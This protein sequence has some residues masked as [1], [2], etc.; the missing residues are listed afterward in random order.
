[1]DFDE[2]NET[3]LSI[4]EKEENSKWI[5]VEEFARK[6]KNEYIT[7]LESDAKAECIEVSKAIG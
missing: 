6:M 3:S 2:I 1:M 7:I 5:E 4:S